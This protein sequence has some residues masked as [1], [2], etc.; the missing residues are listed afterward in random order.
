MIQTK[1]FWQKI[2]NLA[3]IG[4][5]QKKNSADFQIKGLIL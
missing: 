2:E 3:I 4:E 5:M 1:F